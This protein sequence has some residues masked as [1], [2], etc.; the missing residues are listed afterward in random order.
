MHGMQETPEGSF[1]IITRSGD[2]AST[3]VPL[4]LIAVESKLG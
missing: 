3:D 4:N 1:Q 2:V